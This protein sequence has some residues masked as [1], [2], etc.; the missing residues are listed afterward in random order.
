MR[1]RTSDKERKYLPQADGLAVLK[2]C[3][4]E[5]IFATLGG[6]VSLSW[7]ARKRSELKW[8]ERHVEMQSSSNF[9]V[10]TMRKLLA[11][12][13][14]QWAEGSTVLDGKT[15]DQFAKIVAGIAKLEGHWDEL[16]ATQV[17][18]D[19]FVE[20]LTNEAKDQSAYAA[21][22]PHIVEFTQYMRNR[23]DKQ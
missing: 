15:T 8:N 2:G 11:T 12:T 10:E 9:I 16:A 23:S 3:S 7:I 1:I 19:R 6:A 21:L 4:D 22:M 14:R 17:I 5:E 13:V 20:Y 18:M